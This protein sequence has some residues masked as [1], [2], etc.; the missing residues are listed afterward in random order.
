MATRF[1]GTAPSF[2]HARHPLGALPVPHA[3]LYPPVQGPYDM[4]SSP[5]GQHILDYEHP[6]GFVIPPFAMY[7]DSSNPYDHMLHFNQAMIL[8]A[9][10][11][12]LLCK[13]FLASLKGPTLAWFHKL[14]RGSINS[15]G[16]L[17]AVFVS[18]YLCSVNQ[19]GNISSLQAILKRED[20][21]IRD[22]TRRF[23]Q[24]VQ[25][26]DVYSMDAVLQNFR[27]SFRPTTPFF[28]SLSL[29]PPATMEELYWRADKF[30]TL[31]DNIRAALQTVMLTTQSNKLTAKGPSEPKSSQNKGQKRPDGQAEKRKESPQF[32]PL[33]IAYDRLL[34]LIWDLPDFKW[35]PPMRAGPDQ[36][37]RF[38]RCDYHR[39]HTHETNHCQSLKFL[40]K[41]LIRTRHL[42][43]YIREPI[44]GV[45]AAPTADTIIVD[46]EYASRPRQTINFILGG[47]TDN[48]YQSKKQRKKMLHIA[49]VRARVNTVSAQEN[50][51]AVQPVDGPIS[52]PLINPTR[53]ITPHYNALV[54]TVGINGFDVH[55]VLVDPGSAADLLHL[56]AFRQMR[57]QLNHLSFADRV[58]S[59]FNGATTLIV[60]D[61]A[62][63]I[64]AGPVIQ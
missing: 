10:G 29:D 64:Q 16:E 43:R 25:H 26:I 42:K 30:S 9:G 1:G 31:E 11:D 51:T 38:L 39:D 22:F 20:E 62:F 58:L 41:K 61:I 52:F 28:Q 49:S 3:A 19:K 35:P 56:P 15:F 50:I 4:L 6:L 33:N 37:N 27:R 53:V 57:V 63:P 36:R 17:W 47:P 59:G 46:T 45:T 21:S 23:G 48:Q 24:A 54:L 12:R 14:P 32:T 8:N 5:L 34:P 2:L 55:R 18:Q 7:D 44:S 40:V 60:G 13:V